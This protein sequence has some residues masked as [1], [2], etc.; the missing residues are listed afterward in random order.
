MIVKEI[1]PCLALQPFV[2]NYLLVHLEFMPEEFRMK[3][4]P[5]RVEQS[6]NFFVKGHIINHNPVT[7]KVDKIAPNAI[8]GQQVSRL[9]FNTC[10]N[11]EFLMLMVIF[12]PAGMY[13]FLGL[14]SNEL[15]TEFCDAEALWGA[16]LQSVNDQ[17]ANAK[18]YDEI[19]LGAEGYLLR[20]LKSIKKEAHQIDNIG[21]LLLHNPNPFSLDWLAN[22]ACLS[23]RQFERKFS[24]R[25]GVGPKLYSRMSRFFQ[26]FNYKETNQYLD[27]LSVA[28]HFGY[29]DYYHLVKDFKQFA[30]VTPNLLLKE[31]AKRPEIIV[32]L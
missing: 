28:V 17:L 16:E 22:Q 2:R 19:I 26:A 11:P 13:R 8:F 7:G 32:S 30:N 9:N 14:S 18:N 10:P 24:E 21:R 29:T 3:P 20:K 25:M 4:Y 5:A 31:N 27:W 12:Q 23:P 1:L 6:L 15:T